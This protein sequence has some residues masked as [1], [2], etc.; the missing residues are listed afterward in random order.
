MNR[1]QRALLALSGYQPLPQRPIEEVVAEAVNLELQRAAERERQRAEKREP[2]EITVRKAVLEAKMDA[3][4]LEVDVVRAAAAE[5]AKALAEAPWYQCP[6]CGGRD[7][8]RIGTIIGYKDLN[9]VAT[10]VERGAR[11]ACQ[12]CPHVFS[13]GPGGAFNQHPLSHPITPTMP[14]DY[15]PG[16]AARQ[17]RGGKTDDELRSR[18][19]REHGAIPR[20]RPAP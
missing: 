11:V 7:Y 4:Q 17:Q 8:L 14:P 3:Q 10:V 20:E 19:I 1:F 2:L 13:V 9:G 18:P 16:P 15:A 5:A 12:R 6:E